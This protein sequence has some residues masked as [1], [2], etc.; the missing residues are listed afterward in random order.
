MSHGM[1]CYLVYHNTLKEPSLPPICV[2]IIRTSGVFYFTQRIETREITGKLLKAVKQT[3]ST[4]NY[5]NV[6]KFCS[7]IRCP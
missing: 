2:C 6:I 5:H 4:T 7:T 3:S 1:Y